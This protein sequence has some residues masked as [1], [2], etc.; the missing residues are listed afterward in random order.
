MLNKIR[1]I[2][3]DEG[4][5]TFLQRAAGRISRERLRKERKKKLYKKMLEESDHRKRFEMIYT[6]NLWDSPESR[7]GPGSEI[8]NTAAT[9][10]ALQQIISDKEIK[11]IVDAP[12]GDFHWMQHVVNGTTIRYHG[13]D[14]VQDLIGT[15]TNKFESANISF[16]VGDICSDH[17]PDCDLLIVRDCL[18]H[19]S[20]PDIENFLKNISNTNYRYLFTT[21]F[22][23]QGGTIVLNT[24]ITTGDFRPI[25]L[26][27]WPFSFSIEKVISFVPEFQENGLQR[28]MIL[29]EKKDVP[30]ALLAPDNTTT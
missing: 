12:C 9:M 30:T 13:I 6:N 27:K 2:I 8:S 3:S 21:T 11:T 4:I 14:I 1:Q 28:A 5:K 29:L 25:N 24:D 23:D 10:R 17:I 26:F 22:T 15:N 16:S 7:S 19:L 18:F 20:L